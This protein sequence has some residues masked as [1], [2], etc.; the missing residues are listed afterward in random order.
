MCVFVCMCVCVCVCVC[1]RV[2]ACVVLPV[3]QILR[4]LCW[5]YCAV[6]P[7]VVPRPLPPQLHDVAALLL[8][9]LLLLALR[10][11]L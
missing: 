4:L 3:L 2:R 8:L 9:L 5:W 11:L 1:A 10:L 7:R 6:P